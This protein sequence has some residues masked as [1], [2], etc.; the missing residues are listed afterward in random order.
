[1]PTIWKVY[2]QEDEYP[3]LWQRWYRSQCAAIGYHPREYGFPPIIRETLGRVRPRD[4]VIAYLGKNRL[5]RLGQITELPSK[6]NPLIPAR[7]VYKK[8]KEPVHEIGA[9]GRRIL[10]RWDLT[11]GPS[12]PDIFVNLPKNSAFP[13]RGAI[14]QVQKLK[15]HDLKR[16]L[17]NEKEW[18]PLGNR[19]QYEKSLSDFIADHPG[20]LEYGLVPHPDLAV[21]EYVFFQEKHSDERKR[22]D[23]LLMD[24]HNNHVIV[25]CKQGDPT[26]DCIEQL[27][28]YM[29]RLKR[30]LKLQ[31]WPRGILVHGGTANIVPPVDKMARRHN[32]Q[33]VR[34]HLDVAFQRSG[35][36]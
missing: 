28:G 14:C 30:K 32:I 6:W 13:T 2:C 21:R 3:G 11:V 25:E 17:D 5:G 7:T 23:V 35:G 36:K 9:F 34:Y 12:A 20:R 26:R 4:Y 22:S 24:R 27:L 29:G 1:M 19:F 18:F 15:L 8:G 16:I 33:I 10:V 31:K